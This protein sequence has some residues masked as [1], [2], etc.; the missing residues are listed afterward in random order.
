MKL[1]HD[2]RSGID[3]VGADAVTNAYSGDTSCSSSLPILCIK[4]S[5]VVFTKFT[6]TA[7]HL[8]ASL[9]NGPGQYTGEAYYP[10]ISAHLATTRPVRGNQLCDRATMNAFCSES[11]GP[12]WRAIEHA[13]GRWHLLALGN[14]RNDT[15]LWAAISDQNSNCWN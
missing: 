5:G 3:V 9:I 2:E 7:D 12:G 1:D 15:R 10:W 11:Q 14:V 4:F 8:Y 13:D 6:W